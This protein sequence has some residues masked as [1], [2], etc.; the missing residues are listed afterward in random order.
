MKKITFFFATAFLLTAICLLPTF[1]FAQY[2][3][4]HEFSGVADAQYPTGD[5]FS[6][7]NFLYGMSYHGGIN[8]MGAIFKV[9][10]DGTGIVK[11]LDFAGASNGG[12]PFG[13]LTSDGTFLYGMTG[14][15]GINSMGVI[16]KIK[17][18][19]SAYTKLLDF[20]GTANGGNPNGSLI[21]DG[22]F[23][24]GMTYGGG[25][26]GTGLV[27][28]IKTDGS[29]FTKLLDFTGLNGSNPY[30]SLNTDGTFL[31]GMTFKGGAYG[32]GLI[33]KIKPD[34]TG[35]SKVHDFSGIYGAGQGSLISDGDFL[36]GMGGG[37][38]G[39][40]N[41]FK[42]KKDGSAYA[43][44]FDFDDINGG[45]PQGS[46]IY[47]CPFLYGMTM[48][49]NANYGVA[50]KIK[51]DGAEFT[52]L[53][54]FTQT[55]KE[56]Y[57][58]FISV[59]TELYGMTCY[60]GS[61]DDG[62]IFK[63]ELTPSNDTL[64]NPLVPALSVCEDFFIPNLITP[65]GDGNNDRFEIVS[66]GKHWKVE[67]FNTWG[68]KIFEKGNYKDEWDGSGL[69]EG[70]YY[71]QISDQQSKKQYTGWVHLLR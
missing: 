15:G 3:R 14:I 37:I 11:L 63:Y 71:Y 31:Y 57:G 45:S 8:G 43:S 42:V 68:S 49:G 52:N 35:Y 65:N 44:L 23:L 34:G 7:G 25:A 54:N 39:W 48:R 40:G 12:R 55:G 17:T 28:K 47:V 33:F 13:S 50:F 9:K 27:F 58:S 46:L 22:T 41:I 70:I 20:S 10:L 24:Y 62:T 69:T 59:G 56:P 26:N 66:C 29:G 53:I 6:D 32:K 18:D 1:S 51:T 38:Y 36:Y 19:G 60:G 21:Y 30:G 2:T 64:C 61:F 4:L 5:L 67:I 16:F